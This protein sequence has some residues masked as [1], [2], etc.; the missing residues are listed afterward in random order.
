MIKRREKTKREDLHLGIEIFEKRYQAK[1]F[2][3]QLLA[4][5][6]NIAVKSTRYVMFNDVECKFYLVLESKYPLI[7]INI[8]FLARLLHLYM[9]INTRISKPIRIG[10]IHL[11]TMDR[12]SIHLR[13]ADHPINEVIL[14]QISHIKMVKKKNDRIKNGNTKINVKSCHTLVQVNFNKY[15]YNRSN[16]SYGYECFYLKRSCGRIDALI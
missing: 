16:N 6:S 4:E 11:S 14:T 2:N 3:G 10:Q 9:A 5:F 15:N 13:L 1:D 8:S 7:I 12:A